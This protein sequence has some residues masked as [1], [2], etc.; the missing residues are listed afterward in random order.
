MGWQRNLVQRQWGGVG[1]TPEVTRQS[2]RDQHPGGPCG[3]SQEA[4]WACILGNP[5]GPRVEMLAQVHSLLSKAGPS[6]GCRWA[7]L[8]HAAAVHHSG[9]ACCL[10]QTLSLLPP[11][12]RSPHALARCTQP[13]QPLLFL[14]PSPTTLSRPRGHPSSCPRQHTLFPLTGK[15]FSKTWFEY[16]LLWSLSCPPPTSSVLAHFSPVSLTI[17]TPTPQ[18]R[19]RSVAMTS[20]QVCQPY[21]VV[22]IQSQGLSS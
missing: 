12:P 21:W 4:D 22:D 20:V 5:P 6:S 15:A 7:C 11:A 17:P 2:C 8:V 19:T 1:A 9:Q 16:F 10:P 3:P 13:C 14:R 18:P